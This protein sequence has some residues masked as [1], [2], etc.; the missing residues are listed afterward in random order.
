[1]TGTDAG[2]RGTPAIDPQACNALTTTPAGLLVP[3]TSLAALPSSAPAP[4]GA[5]RS[6]DID[7]VHPGGCPDAWQIGARLSPVSG[8]AVLATAANLLPSPGAWVN[9]A[10]VVTLPEPGR[11][12]LSWDARAQICAQ[13]NYCT[14]AWIEGAV[15]DNASGA[16][17][18][19]PRTIMQHQF[20]KANDGSVLQTCQSA[21]SPITHISVV[22]AA[23]GSRTLRLRGIFQNSTTCANTVFQ[24]ATMPASRNYVTWTKI[25]D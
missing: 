15:F 10:L 21:T 23:Q 11:Y 4:V 5:T 2:L 9:T 12:Y 1:M 18:A 3:R 19:G 24:S 6:V 22:T 8:E 13:V 17:E 25:T 7:L 20:S 16:V 14:N